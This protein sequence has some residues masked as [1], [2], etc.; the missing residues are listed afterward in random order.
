MQDLLQLI[1]QLRTDY[2]HEIVRSLMLIAVLL[3]IRLA[4]G[5]ILSSNVSVPVEERRAGRSPPAMCCSFPAWPA[6]A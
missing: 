6:S 5:H 2:S 1:H 4:V 3:L